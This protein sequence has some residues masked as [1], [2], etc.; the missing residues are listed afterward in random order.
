[1][2]EDLTRLTNTHTAVTHTITHT[3]GARKIG[4]RAAARADLAEVF[5][6][7]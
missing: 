3:P 1:M 4:V 5:S 6:L 2:L 7:G